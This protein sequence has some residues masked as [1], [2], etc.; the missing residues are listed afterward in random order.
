MKLNEQQNF[1]SEQLGDDKLGTSITVAR[2]AEEAA[3]IQ[4]VSSRSSEF[5]PQAW[6]AIN[7]K[8]YPRF[9]R[10]QLENVD[11]GK[12]SKHLETLENRHSCRQFTSAP[13]SLETLTN[14]LGIVAKTRSGERPRR[15]Y[16]SA[17]MRW[18]VEWYLAAINVESLDTGIYHYESFEHALELL[19]PGEHW[20]SLTKAF[21]MQDIDQPA[22]VLI[23]TSAFH[24]SWIKYGARGS[25][26]AYMEVGAAAMCLDLVATET[27]IGV[28]WLGGFVDSIVAELLDIDW[29]MELEA[30]VL[31]L[32]LGHPK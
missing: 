30:P 3:W 28:V 24:R 13:I 19:R 32:A 1:G 17:G 18:P 25:R 2:A 31:C 12:D 8:F 21:E 20:Q 7:K 5:F 9:P 11:N 15:V 29:Q 14:L 16:P 23:L 10:V 26:F 22:A 4:S 27:N 6:T